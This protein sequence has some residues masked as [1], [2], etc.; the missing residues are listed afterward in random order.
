MS[1]ETER[2]E[3]RYESPNEFRF[4]NFGKPREMVL[5]DVKEFRSL[6]GDRVILAEESKKLVARRAAI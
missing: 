2:V 4:G 3:I 5:G 1:I 6:G